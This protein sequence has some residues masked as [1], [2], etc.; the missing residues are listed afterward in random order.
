M[1]FEYKYSLQEVIGDGG[2]KKADLDNSKELL[3]RIRGELLDERSSGSL[4]FMDL[5]YDEE[6]VTRVQELA[7]EH[8]NRWDNLVVLGI[9]GS[10]LGNITIFEALSNVFHNELPAGK[11]GGLPR[12]YA[13]DNI[14]P[15]LFSEL[16]DHLD[17]KKTLF[18]VISKSG[19][20]PETA[21][22]FVV[23]WDLLN[24]V[25]G[26]NACDHMVAITDQS[27]G[28]LREIVS[29][30]GIAALPVPYG[31]GGRFSV[32]SDVGLFSSVLLGVDIEKLLE[33][34]RQMDTLFKEADVLDCPP[35]V[36]AMIHHLADVKYG[37]SISVM[38]YY[39][40]KLRSFG[41]W[42]RQ[43]WAE[44]LGKKVDVDGNIVNTGQ[45]P[46]TAL[47][48]TDQHSQ[49]QL[50]NEGPNDKIHTFISI[51]DYGSTVAIPDVFKEF[52][53][54]NYM[55]G[56][57]LN[58]L[59]SYEAEATRAAVS[60]NGRP[61]V[62]ITLSRLNEFELGQLFFM[63]ELQTAVAGKLYNIDAFD[64][65]GV[66]KGK[67]YTFGL[68]GRPGYEKYKAEVDSWNQK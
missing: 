9:G 40:N 36:N 51:E 15:K 33:G 29:K 54:V 46:V 56:R 5:P 18:C 68:L 63:Y 23:V 44:S 32:L 35:L 59:I 3:E 39:S 64:Q 30:R 19:T 1:K 49:L 38:M 21:A 25:I 4:K 31:V 58:E 47:G 48:A 41:D 12:F 28:V 65:P 6:M 52:E 42:Y 16:L 61:N 57:T 20:T 50:Y 66:E 60:S 14:D 27:S 17:L 62:R 55:G 24:K 53:A 13:A 37:K 10:A 26:E 45:T 22:S 34:A 43:L 67:L 2:I 7:F 8:V 11:R